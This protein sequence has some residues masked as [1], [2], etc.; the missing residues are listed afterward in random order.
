MNDRELYQ[1]ALGK[2]HASD[3]WKQRTLA[4]MRAAQ[5]QAP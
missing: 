5:G 2:V 4:A 1:S 3:A